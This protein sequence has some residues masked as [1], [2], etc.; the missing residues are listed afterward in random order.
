MCVWHICTML[1]IYHLFGEIAGHSIPIFRFV[2][3]ASK[4]EPSVKGETATL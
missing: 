3:L 1:L 4:R 2:T